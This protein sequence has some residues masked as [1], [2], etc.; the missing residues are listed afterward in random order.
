MQ[1]RC[2]HL[3]SALISTRQFLSSLTLFSLIYL[4]WLYCF[5][6]HSH[7][8]LISV[9][10]SLFPYPSIFPPALFRWVLYLSFL[11]LEVWGPCLGLIDGA[12]TDV[13]PPQETQTRQLFS[14]WTRHIAFLVLFSNCEDACVGGWGEGGLR[15]GGNKEGKQKHNNRCS[16][17]V[18][19]NAATVHKL[20]YYPSTVYHYVVDKSMALSAMTPCYSK[21][22]A[23]RQSPCLLWSLQPGSTWG[24]DAHS[25]EACV[26]ACAVNV[27]LCHYW[28]G[29]FLFSL[30]V[31]SAFLCRCRCENLMQMCRSSSWK[32]HAINGIL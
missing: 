23:L 21:H 25:Q 28:H 31:L 3:G 2:S 12:A 29:E 6:S 10:V 22:K 30:F 14:S 16:L 26:Q 18:Q 19:K 5:F 9:T 11:Y 7:S 15:G 17:A 24:K 4:L 32:H 20:G 27:C 1:S 13:Q 8:I